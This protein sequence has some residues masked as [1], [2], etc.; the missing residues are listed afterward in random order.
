[1]FPI[2]TGTSIMWLILLPI[3]AAVMTPF[4][5]QYRTAYYIWTLTM[6]ALF[7]CLIAVTPVTDHTVRFSNVFVFS[8]DKY[9]WLFTLLIGI[10]WF[11]TVLYGSAYTRFHLSS[12]ADKFYAYLNVTVAVITANSLAG[13][14]STL[15]LF[16]M[17][18][19]PLIYPLITIPNTRE[20]R[21]AAKSYLLNVGLPPLLI[22]LPVLGYIWY[23]S[24]SME[25][26]HA[27]HDWIHSEPLLGSLILFLFVIGFSK[28][29]VAPFH[30]W[31]PRTAHA[32]SP[33]SA[34]VHSVASVQTGTVALVKIAVY[35]YGLVNMQALNNVVWHTGWLNY[36]CGFTAVY[37]AWKAYKTH[38]LKKRFSF[39]TVGQ[40][41]YIITAIL[42]GT[43]ASLMGSMLH[44]VTH[45]FAKMCLFF[46]A[47]FYESSYGTVKTHDITKI[48]P[49]HKWIVVA[50]GIAGLSI[51]GFPFLAGYYSKDLML[52]EEIHTKHYASALFLLMGSVINFMYILPVL[53]AGFLT[54]VRQP[55]IVKPVPPSMAIAISICCLAL[56]ALNFYVYHI[57]RLL[58][59]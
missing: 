23:R 15:F 56:L 43:S 49:Y 57:M 53:K 8:I 39:S 35:F 29:S 38:D 12:S 52:L 1:M 36:L 7:I 26:H 54:K 46:V 40:L 32:P 16:Y 45:S 30:L 44:I 19:I 13:N 6:A 58:A 10:C 20:M 5:V 37:T 18:S 3:F 11:I 51:T 14:L 24:G 22:V 42:I 17:L 21:F 55:L 27:A 59:Q 31:L 41:S 33:V 9:S 25:F 2:E 48:A 28:N 50:V 4:K 47:G 34:L